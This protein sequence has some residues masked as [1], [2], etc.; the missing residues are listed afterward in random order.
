MDLPSPGIVRS[1]PTLADR[2]ARATLR[3]HGFTSR[4]IATSTGRIHAVDIREH[5]DLPPVL[6]LHGFSAAGVHWFPLLRRLQRDTRRLVAPDLPGHGFSDLPEGGLDPAVVERGLMEALDQLIGEPVVLLGNS[7]G[8]MAAVRYATRRPQAVR[9]L[10][11]ISPGGAPMSETDLARFRAGFAL[12]AHEDALEFVDRL[13]DRPGRMRSVL[14]WGVRERFR[15]EAMRHLI[16]ALQA[17]HLLTADEVAALAQPTLLL[18]GESERILPRDGLA[19]F[20]RHLPD[21]AWIEEPQG[22]GHSP[23]LERP[24]E[25]AAWVRRFLRRY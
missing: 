13:M 4:R 23:Y 11:L 21:D 18:W 19:F 22:W 15:R 1:L 8:G 3:W 6:L 25:V 20:R 7:M 9:G 14:A 5:G 2:L 10:I 16:G 24:D 17:E 12:D